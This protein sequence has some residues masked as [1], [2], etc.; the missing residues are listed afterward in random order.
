MYHLDYLNQQEQVSILLTFQTVQTDGTFSNFSI[1]YLS[2]SD[3]KL[4]KSII[5][6][7][8]DL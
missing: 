7:S 2:T 8:F 3:F 1:S 4:A 5:L 6:T